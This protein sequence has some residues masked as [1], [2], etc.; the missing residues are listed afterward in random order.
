M[1]R[2][3]QA[4]E[5]GLV[6]KIGTYEDA[7]EAAAKLGGIKGDY[8][9]TTLRGGV[10]TCFGTLL[11]IERQLDQLDALLAE[12]RGSRCAAVASASSAPAPTEGGGRA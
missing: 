7:L 10:P 12:R 1:E 4:K 3:S 6:D 2:R 11:G 8:E 5:L 9:V